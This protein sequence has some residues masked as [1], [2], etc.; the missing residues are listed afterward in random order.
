MSTS[1]R[2]LRRLRAPGTGVVVALLASPLLFPCFAAADSETAQYTEPPP[3][4]VRDQAPR[5]AQRGPEVNQP[6][7]PS[8]GRSTDGA[9]EGAS[10]SAG[11]PGGGSS[12]VA[13]PLEGESGAAVNALAIAALL[14]ALLCL[15]VLG[16]R[17]RRA[18][19]APATAR[20][21]PRRAAQ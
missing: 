9:S 2:L 5:G 21:G 15:A 18:P 3:A 17:L 4:S 1:S 11:K 14:V 16:L 7:G 13:A 19:G 8:R 12:I 6:S 10:L 20:A